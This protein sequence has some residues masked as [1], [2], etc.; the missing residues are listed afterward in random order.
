[1]VV[2]N[3]LFFPQFYKSDMSRYGYLEV[4]QSPLEFEIT[5]VDCITERIKFEN[6]SLK[7]KRSPLDQEI[8]QMNENNRFGF[9]E[10]A[11][12]QYFYAQPCPYV[13]VGL[14]EIHF[15]KKSKWTY[16]KNEFHCPNG[17]C[18]PRGPKYKLH[19]SEV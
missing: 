4:F 7:R 6:R 5:R 3:E 18:G 11:P 9:I 16:S 15:S 19:Q 17:R 14:S 12:A 1:M 10:S 8:H 13:L 2:R